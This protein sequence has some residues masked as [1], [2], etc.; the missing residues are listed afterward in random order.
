MKNLILRIIPVECTGLIEMFRKSNSHPVFS[1][2]A[3]K[4]L[5]SGREKFDALFEDIRKAR[6]HIHLDY[7]IVETGQN[8]IRIAAASNREGKRRS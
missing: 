6:K 7:Y 1:G 4:L 5:T 8:R 3:V 2:N